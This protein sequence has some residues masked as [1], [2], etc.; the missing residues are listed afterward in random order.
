[1]K[2]VIDL[3]GEALFNFSLSPSSLSID[4]WNSLI[5]TIITP[6]EVYDF[7]QHQLWKVSNIVQ[8]Q[9]HNISTISE[10]SLTCKSE[11]NALY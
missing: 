2:Y 1:M 11:V 5:F 7:R 10:R 8:K 4:T 3:L 6:I 9:I